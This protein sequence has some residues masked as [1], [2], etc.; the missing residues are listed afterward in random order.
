MKYIEEKRDLFT[1]DKKEYSFAHCISSDCK[2][3]A[4]IA[5]PM[6]KTFRLSGL[7][8][9]PS[10]ERE[11]PTCIYYNGVYNLITKKKYSGKPTY[12]TIRMSLVIMRNHALANN[13]TRI[14]MPKIGCGLDKLQ[15]AMVRAI[16]H[17]LFEDTDIE[18]RVC[19]Q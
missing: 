2:M 19:K 17:E 16:I 6:K 8:K 9:F 11:H 1:L 18:I 5:T 15:W 7:E 4:G 10:N 3:G 12:Q 14:A 13:I